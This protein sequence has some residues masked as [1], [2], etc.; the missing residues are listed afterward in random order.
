MYITRAERSPMLR[1]S[2]RA[3][4]NWLWTQAPCSWLNKVEIEFREVAFENLE[5]ATTLKH[6]DVLATWTRQI[7]CR[8]IVP[9]LIVTETGRDT[10]Y[11]QDGNHRYHAMK[12]CYHGQLRRMRLRVAVMKPR[13]GYRFAYRYFGAYGTYILQDERRGRTV[14]FRRTEG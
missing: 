3:A 11:I 4:Y 5:P 1:V 7:A 9:P 13:P 12:I 8:R 14:R 6:W 2:D 10:Y